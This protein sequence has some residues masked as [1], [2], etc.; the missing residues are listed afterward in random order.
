M[1]MLLAFQDPRE[2]EESRVCQARAEKGNRCRIICTNAKLKILNLGAHG[3]CYIYFKSCV[4]LR[5]DLL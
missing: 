5:R 2:R 4:L 1:A 3:F